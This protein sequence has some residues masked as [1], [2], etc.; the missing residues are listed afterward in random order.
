MDYFSDMP[1]GERD[2]FIQSILDHQGEPNR[3]LLLLKHSEEYI[4]FVHMKINDEHPGWGLIM[5]FYIVPNKRRLG[6]GRRLFTLCQQI[7][8]ERGV[9]NVWLL[10][11][12]PAE[13][14]WQSLGFRET[15][16]SIDGRRVWAASI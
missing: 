7:L 13:P 8:R 11:H 14:F 3:W 4:G 5:E 12:P 15:G 1:P 16:E 10:T 9:S 2:R 6:W